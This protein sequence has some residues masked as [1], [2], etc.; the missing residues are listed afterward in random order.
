MKNTKLTKVLPQFSQKNSSKEFGEEKLW[1]AVPEG[2]Y[3]TQAER[4]GAYLKLLAFLDARKEVGKKN[5]S[6]NQISKHLH[7]AYEKYDQEMNSPGFQNFMLAR[8]A[9]K[10]QGTLSR[11]AGPLSETLI[12]LSKD[13]T[14]KDDDGNDLADSK[15]QREFIQ[16]I[17]TT[18]EKFGIQKIDISH[19][20][21]VNELDTDE[22]IEE[23]MRIVQELKG[24]EDVVQWFTRVAT[25]PLGA[26]GSKGKTASA[27]NNFGTPTS[28]PS[29]RPDTPVEAVPVRQAPIAEPEEVP[30][31]GGMQPPVENGLAD[32]GLRTSGDGETPNIQDP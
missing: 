11:I 2:P 28:R 17:S 3:K 25:E 27:G 14:K 12:K 5:I 30:V 9:I 29:D 26:R 31:D 20:D 19:A 1:E 13:I 32:I 7:M 15:M 6:D 24:K 21:T 8:A 23:G 18:M 22:A 16:L 10:I 4:W